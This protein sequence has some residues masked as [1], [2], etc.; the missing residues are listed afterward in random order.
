M[1]RLGS[2]VGTP[3]TC[4]DM[5]DRGECVLAFPEGVRGMNKTYADAY[6]A[7]AGIIHVLVNGVP[8]VRDQ[9]VQPDVYPGRVLAAPKT[10]R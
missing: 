4:T 7:S 3:R 8:V 5:L 2:A 1:D 10:A 9:A 6:Q